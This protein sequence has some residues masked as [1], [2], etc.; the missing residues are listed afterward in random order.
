MVDWVDGAS[1]MMRAFVG[2]HFHSAGS[3]RDFAQC[4]IDG[5]E[6]GNEDTTITISGMAT[7]R[8]RWTQKRKRK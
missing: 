5:L 6:S 7:P 2:L 3:L 1:G 8:R 4:I